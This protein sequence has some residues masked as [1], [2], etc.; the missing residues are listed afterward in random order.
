MAKLELLDFYAEWCGPCKTMT[1]VI[2]DLM[3]EYN[4]DG[5]EVEVKKVN[6]D[7][8]PDMAQKYGIR[9][10]PAFIFVKEGE[11]VDRIVGATS[12]SKLV[13]KLQALSAV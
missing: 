8:E 4:V 13:E 11:A 5:S 9:G 1:P 6:V 10:I 12:K 2:E 3:K 7:N